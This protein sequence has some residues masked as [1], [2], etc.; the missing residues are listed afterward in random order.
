MLHVELQG[1]TCPP[2]YI[3]KVYFASRQ[4]SY[5]WLVK[6]VNLVSA[7]LNI[8]AYFGFIVL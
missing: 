7:L 8:L 2:I 4:S 5:S 3:S 1:P 6:M